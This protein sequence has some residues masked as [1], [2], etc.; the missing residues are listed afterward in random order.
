MSCPALKIQAN[1]MRDNLLCGSL[2]GLFFCLY[3]E[4]VF[5][6][7]SRQKVVK[8]SFASFASV[9]R[10]LMLYYYCKLCITVGTDFD[11]C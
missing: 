6:V 2:L 4:N 9:S 8:Y 11:R 3:V 1:A 5:T 10:C 7:S